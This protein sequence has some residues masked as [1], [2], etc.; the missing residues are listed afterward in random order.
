MGHPQ[1]WQG[2]GAQVMLFAFVPS[3]WGMGQPIFS[4]PVWC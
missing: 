2:L 3:S 4:L 1:A